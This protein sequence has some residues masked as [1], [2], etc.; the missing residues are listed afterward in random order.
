MRIACVVLIVFLFSTV[1][2]FGAGSKQLAELMASD[3]APTDDFGV[4]VAASGNT[5]VVGAPDA[6]VGSNAYEGGDRT[7]ANKVINN[8][9]R[10]LRSSDI[11][12]SPLLRYAALMQLC[13]KRLES[14]VVGHEGKRDGENGGH[15]RSR[16]APFNTSTNKAPNWRN[17]L[18]PTTG[19]V[20]NCRPP[21]NYSIRGHNGV[22]RY[23]SIGQAYRGVGTFQKEAA[24]FFKDLWGPAMPS[25]R[26]RRS[27]I[28]PFVTLTYH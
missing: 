20:P 6:T 21:G 3:G 24:P 22:Y 5:V 23:E 15:L 13:S 27:S 18:S 14:L 7:D 1:F 4:S 28:T 16:C 8:E 12:I 2:C 19:P 17:H 11:W 26:S 10:G 9:S 25:A